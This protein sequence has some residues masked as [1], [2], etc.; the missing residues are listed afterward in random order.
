L[1]TGNDGASTTFSGS[2]SGTGGLTKIGSGTFVLSGINSHSGATVVNGGTLDVTGSIAA[3]VLT[4]VNSTAALTGTGAVGATSIASGGTF[5]PGNG[6][7]GTFMT[8]SSVSHYSD[9]SFT[10]A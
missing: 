8:V 10:G 7:P 4:T 2:I 3:S 5:A 9:A 1:T 6:T